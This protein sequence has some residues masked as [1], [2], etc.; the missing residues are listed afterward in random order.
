MDGENAV[1][2]FLMA[3]NG[4]RRN[5]ERAGTVVDCLLGGLWLRREIEVWGVID[6]NER[7]RHRAGGWQPPKFSI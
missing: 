1:E 5:K 7:G 2:F 6:G 4:R 3:S